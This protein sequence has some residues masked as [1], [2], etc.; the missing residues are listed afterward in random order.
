M[1]VTGLILAGGRSSRME[2]NDKGLLKLLER[3]MI[4]HVIERL[5]P[6]VDTVLISANRHIEQYQ[7]YG[8][9]VLIDKYDDFRGPLAG[10]SRGLEASNS[11]YLLT[12]PCDGPLLP[13]DLAQRM[14]KSIQQQQADAALVYDGKYK[15]P[16]YN[17]IHHRLQD[18]I[19][20][21]LQCNEHKLGKWLMDHGALKV[22]FSEQKVAFIN[23]N[24]P[25]DLHKLEQQL[26][27][28]LKQQGA[29]KK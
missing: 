12:V 1:Q 23:V 27:R 18:D 11:D 22:D 10:M 26:K 17:L 19:N 6:Q 29:S 21:S 9:K 2:G 28:Q 8:Y 16:T 20:H 14:L 24:T 13:V 4:E 3:P 7:Q 15:Q 25:D 5:K